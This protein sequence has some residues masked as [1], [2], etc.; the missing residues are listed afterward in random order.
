MTLRYNDR[1][2]LHLP[3]D[4][5]R[6]FNRVGLSDQSKSRLNLWIFVTGYISLQHLSI[7]NITPQNVFIK[8]FH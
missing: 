6:I 1:Y 8:G 4:K 2:G 7:W 3:M 5:A